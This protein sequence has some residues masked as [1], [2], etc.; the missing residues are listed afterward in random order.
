MAQN[1]DKLTNIIREV[2]RNPQAFSQIPGIGQVFNEL[3]EN[4]G[5]NPIDFNKIVEPTAKPEVQQP[6][7]ITK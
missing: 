2:M 1:A 5:L 6:N 3:L 4:S 7:Q